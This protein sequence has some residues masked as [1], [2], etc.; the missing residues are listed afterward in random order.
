M[1]DGALNYAVFRDI[2]PMPMKPEIT[3]IVVSYNAHEELRK[4]LTSLRASTNIDLHIVVIDNASTDGNAD[5]VRKDFPDCML[6]VNVSN[7]GFAA[8]VNQGLAKASGDVILI[9]PDLTVMPDTI[10]VL[11][12][13][14]DTH[15][16]VGIVGPKLTYPDGTLQPSVKKFPDWFDLFLILSKVPNFV[17]SVARVYNGLTVDYGKEQTVDQVMG[18]CFLIRRATLDAVGTFDEG[19]WMW[20]EE[21]DFCKRALAKGWT[22]LYTPATHAIH[23]RAAS[24]TQSTAEK[25]RVL[26]NSIMHYSTKYFGAIRTKMLGPAELMSVLTGVVGEQVKLVKPYKAKHL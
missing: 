12:R 25:Q 10:A 2:L 17:P 7:R 20:F 15:T 26:R 16:N 18:S 8:A 4:C 5:M 9:N 14:L 22:T 1:H 13:T 24:T 23:V 19:F 3:A 11:K 21:V 6:I